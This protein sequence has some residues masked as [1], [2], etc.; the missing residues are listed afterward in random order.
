MPHWDFRVVEFI[1]PATGAMPAERWREIH[2]V[3]YLESGEPSFYGRAAT[4]HWSPDEDGDDPYS[5]L[6]RMKAALTKP[7]L[8]EADFVGDVLTDPRMIAITDAIEGK[9]D[10]G[11]ALLD[12]GL[13]IESL[14]ELGQVVGAIG[15]IGENH[16]E[17]SLASRLLKMLHEAAC[18]FDEREDQQ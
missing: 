10:D 11:Q 6:E 9:R 4:V 7:V 13:R 16:P 3:Y 15:K 14:D 5:V 8:T 18:E 17:G 2:E 1:K 12:A